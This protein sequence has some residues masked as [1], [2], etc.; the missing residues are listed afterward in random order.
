MRSPESD[1]AALLGGH[2]FFGVFN[3][4]NDLTKTFAP[5][6]ADLQDDTR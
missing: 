4:I 3:M 6:I 1:K 2:S 5:T